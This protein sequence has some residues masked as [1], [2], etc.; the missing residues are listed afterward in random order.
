M[1][2]NKPVWKTDPTAIGIVSQVWG[3][4]GPKALAAA[5]AIQARQPD[6]KL[7]QALIECGAMQPQQLRDVLQKQQ[8]MRQ[9]KSGKQDV[10]TLLDFATRRTLQASTALDK[11]TEA[12]KHD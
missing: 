5:L 11:I 10:G 3:N 8:Q 1:D 7:G 6:K 2:N 12:L 9:G 4:V